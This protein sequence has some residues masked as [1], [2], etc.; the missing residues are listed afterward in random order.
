VR[1]RL[2]V[3]VE[4]RF[5]HDGERV[6]RHLPRDVELHSIGPPVRAPARVGDHR[7]AVAGDA[8]AV[9]CRLRETALPQ[10]EI[11]LAGEQPLAEQELGAFQAAALV[12]PAAVRDEDVADVLGVAEQHQRL[13]TDAERR[14]VAEVAGERGEEL[15]RTPDDGQSELAGIAPAR[16]RDGRCGHDAEDSSRRLRPSGS[17]RYDP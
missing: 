14:N 15:Q 9:K 8:R 10:V 2:D 3:G 1:L 16:A 13:R 5:S 17:V 12:E 4:Q 7:I 11:V 6:R